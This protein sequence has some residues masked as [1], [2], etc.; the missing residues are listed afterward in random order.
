MK[1]VVIGNGI[2][3]ITAALK[4]RELRPDWHITVVSRESE[5]FFSRP[6][7]MYIYMGHMSLADTQPHD[8]GFWADRDLVLRQATVTG[9]DTAAQRVL[10]EQG[11]ALAY[12]KLLLATGSQSNKFGWPGQ[13]LRGVQGLYSFQDLKLM[14]RQTQGITGA[15]IVGGG[16]ASGEK[17]CISPIQ[18]VVDGMKVRVVD[19]GEDAAAATT[20][21]HPHAAPAVDAS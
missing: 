7:L 5:H 15:V 17:I 10:L 16:L 6:A 3:G 13:D 4:I 8:P 12:D 11:D 14:Q 19:A 18:A 1:I 2:T 21:K 9:I 20:A